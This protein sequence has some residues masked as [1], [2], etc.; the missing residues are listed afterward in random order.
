[1]PL[2]RTP[3]STRLTHPRNACLLPRPPFRRCHRSHRSRPRPLR[4]HPRTHGIQS[5]S[6]PHRRLRHRRCRLPDL[7]SR[8]LRRTRGLPRR[9]R[10]RRLFLRQ[11]RLQAHR[12]VPGCASSW[13]RANLAVDPHPRRKRKG[14]TLQAARHD[15]VRHQPA[16]RRELR[17]GPLLRLRRLAPRLSLRRAPRLRLH[18]DCPR[19]R[20]RRTDPL[21]AHRRHR[22]PPRPVLPLLHLRLPPQR[23]LQKGLPHHLRSF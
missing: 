3:S 14:R 1:M 17:M 11:N 18:R 10:G 19:R 7:R 8:R 13:R 15:E 23:A 5:G 4:R 20:V 2:H 22:P 9:P 16:H 12:P 6:R 21:Q